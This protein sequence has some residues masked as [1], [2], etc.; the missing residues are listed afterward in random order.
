[1]CMNT[2]AAFHDRILYLDTV[3][4]SAGGGTHEFNGNFQRFKEGIEE[5]K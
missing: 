2:P 5:S 3:N 1:M 4:P